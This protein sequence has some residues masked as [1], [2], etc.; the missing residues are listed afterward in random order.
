LSE[1]FHSVTFEAQAILHGLAPDTGYSGFLLH[2]RIT[3]ASDALSAKL[4]GRTN[5]YHVWEW[6]PFFRCAADKLPNEV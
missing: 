5:T 6:Q 3:G 4:T 2:G 1:R